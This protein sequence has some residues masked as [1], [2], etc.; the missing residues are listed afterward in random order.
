[1][2][3]YISIFFFSW[4]IAGFELLWGKYL[5]SYLY[6]DYVLISVVFLSLRR[7]SLSGMFFSIWSA[8]FL[9]LIV[10]GMV[11]WGMLV[12]VTIAYLYGTWRKHLSLDRFVNIFLLFLLSSVIYK[13]I[14]DGILILKDNA[15]W[16]TYGQAFPGIVIDSIIGSIVFYFYIRGKGKE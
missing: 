15:G 13:L 14:I 5:P 10:P 4:L 8:L 2:K 11:G 12:L 1:M 6:I 9:F 3:Q 16:K 7:G